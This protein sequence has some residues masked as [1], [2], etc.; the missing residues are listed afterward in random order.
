M[1]PIRIARWSP[2]RSDHGD[3]HGDD[4]GVAQLAPLAWSMKNCG[5]RVADV[6]LREV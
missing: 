4:V 6:L 1:I 5:D 2:S 3:L